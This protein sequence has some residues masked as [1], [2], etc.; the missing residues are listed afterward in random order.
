MMAKDQKMVGLIGEF[1]ILLYGQF[2]NI[3]NDLKVMG[4]QANLKLALIKNFEITNV[5]ECHQNILH[6]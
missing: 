2:I 6:I 4:V 1:G 5:G 3:L